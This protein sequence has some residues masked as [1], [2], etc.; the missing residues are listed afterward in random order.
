MREVGYDIPVHG[1]HAQ[2]CINCSCFCKKIQ[3]LI[4]TYYWKSKF[5]FSGQTQLHKC[6]ASDF[7]ME[8]D[9]AML[10][11][12]NFLDLHLGAEQIMEGTDSCV[13]QEYAY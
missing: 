7:H 8:M 11:E 10:V 5:R 2:V 13:D 1:I 3:C 12:N 9:E 6:K 4:F